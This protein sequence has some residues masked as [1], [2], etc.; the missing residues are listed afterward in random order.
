MN[1]L[2][3]ARPRNGIGG[4]VHGQ[5]KGSPKPSGNPTNTTERTEPLGLSFRVGG[6]VRKVLVI[7]SPHCAP[8]VHQFRQ[9]WPQ[10]G[11]L[12]RPRVNKPAL[13]R[14]RVH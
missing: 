5:G 1:I 9:L 2:L 12:S 14:G 4:F 10:V 3:F 11:L 6:S 7:P 13:G 8:E